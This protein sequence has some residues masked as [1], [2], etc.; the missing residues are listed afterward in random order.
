MCRGWERG[1]R[2]LQET[3]EEGDP[4][5]EESNTGVDLVSINHGVDSDHIL[6]TPANGTWSPGE[7]TTA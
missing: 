7:R 3:F 4:I 2:V 5:D 1:S 6:G